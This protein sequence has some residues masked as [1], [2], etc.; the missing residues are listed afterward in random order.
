[1]KKRI[2][3]I[4]SLLLVLL[5][6]LFLLLRPGSEESVTGDNR[7]TETLPSPEVVVESPTAG[8]ADKP[9]GPGQTGKTP[10]A[11][12]LPATWEGARIHGR[13]ILAAT[14]EPVPGALVMLGYTDPGARRRF[15]FRNRGIGTDSRVDGSFV[16][17]KLKPGNYKIAAEKD[18]LLSYSKRDQVPGLLVREENEDIGPII[19]KL[20]PARTL[21]LTVKA[22]AAGTAIG[23]ARVRVPRKGRKV[24]LTDRN[25]RLSLALTPEIWE[26]QIEADGFERVTRSLAM[27]EDQEN[28]YTVFLRPAGSIFGTVTDTDGKPLKGAGVALRG[29]GVLIRSPADAAGKY[30]LDHVPLESR[31]MLIAGFMGMRPD[32]GPA[33]VLDKR[34]PLV[35]VNFQLDHLPDRRGEDIAGIVVDQ[36]HRPVADARVSVQGFQGGSDTTTG[37]DGRFILE[38]AYFRGRNRS[39]LVEAEGFSARREQLP[40]G[41][42]VED[43]VVI[44]KQGFWVEG[45]VLSETGETVAGARIQV[46]AFQRRRGRGGSELFA[47]KNFY[48]DEAGRFRI[49]DLPQDAR[50]SFTADG[51][52]RLENQELVLERDDV[53]VVLPR[54]GEIFGKVVAKASGQPVTS[55]NIRVTPGSLGGG[56][57][58]GGAGLGD[59]NPAW[60]T[61]G[62]DF[63]SRDG[64]F[65][66]GELEP[67]G[68]VDLTVNAEDH[69]T[70]GLDGVIVPKQGEGST[71]T[72][73]L[74]DR[75]LVVAGRVLEDSRAVND[76]EV[77]LL[78]YNEPRASITFNWQLAEMGAV[79]FARHEIVK[80]DGNGSFR[81]ED[82]PRDTAF[83]LLVQGEGIAR[84]RQAGLELK[85]REELAELTLTVIGSGSISG[86]INRKALP[87]AESLTLFGGSERIR[88][89]KRLSSSDDQYT[90]ENLTP[91]NY[92]LI[93]RTGESGGEGKPAQ[94]SI[95]DIVLASG[96]SLTYDLGFDLSHRVSGLVQLNGAPMAYGTIFLA[97]GDLRGMTQ[98]RTA[99]DGSFAFDEVAPG[100]YD[101][102]AFRGTV[103]AGPD[104]NSLVRTHPN[105]KTVVVE[106]E[107][108]NEI[109]QFTMFGN[110]T[111]QIVPPPRA[112]WE[113]M[114]N[115]RQEDGSRFSRRI[116]PGGDGAVVFEAIP[117]GVYQLRYKARYDDDVLAKPLIDKIE[118]PVEGTDVDLG[119]LTLDAG[120]GDLVILLQGPEPPAHPG[121][122]I[123]VYPAGVA[124]NRTDERLARGRVWPEAGR[125]NMAEIPAGPVQVLAVF[126]FGGW[127]TKPEVI[128]T[129][130]ISGESTE[131]TATMTPITDVAL[132]SGDPEIPWTQIS[133]TRGEET[134]NPEPVNNVGSPPNREGLW[135]RYDSGEVRARGLAE[136]DWQVTI[137]DEQGRTWQGTVQ[138]LA[139]Q[140]V[141]LTITLDQG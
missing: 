13:V 96:D 32:R 37:K 123:Q 57:G 115:G 58:R 106:S 47:D 98:T 114:L 40:M 33:P 22:A 94:I 68:S 54:H 140:P 48:S 60:M 39:I 35:E 122:S 64:T 132:E 1:M 89:N 30:R 139:G 43:L 34:N 26:F 21:E 85:S 77:T 53:E 105:R 63:N 113:M 121:F 10:A 116:E 126:G 82:I 45:T 101:L 93:L 129:E 70:N 90:F 11:N 118:M 42:Q 3:L 80:T 107:D 50:F 137:S 4:V 81:F 109:L 7:Q 73:E 75:G 134:L 14:G 112:D 36:Q 27:S 9:E 16:F 99:E 102:I 88:E 131:V 61:G 31:G 72:I 133:F 38:D 125:L 29:S 128:E 117:P 110:L 135:L 74:E 52:A 127:V 69:V 28:K 8:K 44:L 97:T 124:V 108:L 24:H 92:Q 67:G 62:V 71:L 83:D 141:R 138:L 111:G 65:R 103:S 95:P 12:S 78:V 84:A 79:L 59:A 18:L 104:L 51:F 86:R 55:F 49:E 100:T 17:D 46:T 19:L 120:T 76:A 66:I 6:S 87:Y 2:V 91:G 136:G 56:R 15:Q 119:P 41:P 5:L 25:G 20:S 130:I 23:G